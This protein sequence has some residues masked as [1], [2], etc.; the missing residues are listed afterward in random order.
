MWFSLAAGDTTGS[1]PDHDSVGLRRSCLHVRHDRGWRVGRTS[2]YLSRV[3]VPFL[4]V[5][6]LDVLCAFIARENQ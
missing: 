6:A 2:G 1:D 4:P 3:Y 5:V